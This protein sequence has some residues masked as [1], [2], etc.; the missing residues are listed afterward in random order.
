MVGSPVNKPGHPEEA[1]EK[2]GAP[3]LL[4]I[5]EDSIGVEREQ[6][7]VY[8]E[9]KGVME[10]LIRAMTELFLEENKPED[11]LDYIKSFL[12]ERHR[13]EGDVS[14]L[15]TDLREARVEIS[16]LKRKVDQL[17]S[18]LDKYEAV[19]EESDERHK[20]PAE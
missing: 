3:K 8:M 2:N 18:R 7:R 10:S 4:Q 14:V 16:K 15:R 5:E 19:D 9:E 13:P 12:I 1:A 6:F 11:P 17:S 20:K